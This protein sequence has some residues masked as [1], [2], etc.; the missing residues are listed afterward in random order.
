MVYI[1]LFFEYLE[2]FFAK[3]DLRNEFLSIFYKTHVL[4]DFFFQQILKKFGSFWKVLRYGSRNLGFDT[5]LAERPF[6]K[7]PPVC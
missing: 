6:L 1:W 5:H 2:A 4:T 7:I 3:K